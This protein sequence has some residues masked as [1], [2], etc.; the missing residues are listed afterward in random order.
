MIKEKELS[1]DFDSIYL[2]KR[3]KGTLQEAASGVILRKNFADVE[4]LF[5][6]GLLDRY[7]LQ[8]DDHS[9]I[10]T[11][12]GLRYLEYI[13]EQKKER[14]AK[15]ELEKRRFWIPVSISV[16]SLVIA[17]CSVLVQLLKA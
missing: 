2:N 11:P 5:T 10:I 9:F 8:S 3:D 7:A 16:L 13:E 6:Y 4:F 15:E 1:L 14:A 17:V 12:T